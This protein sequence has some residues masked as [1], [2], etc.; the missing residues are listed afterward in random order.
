M[1]KADRH[2]QMFCTIFLLTISERD[3]QY[4]G[5]ELKDWMIAFNTLTNKRLKILSI[6]FQFQRPTHLKKGPK[7]Q[8]R[9]CLKCRTLSTVA[10]GTEKENSPLEQS[11]SERPPFCE[12]SSSQ[13]CLW[14]FKK[15]LWRH[16]GWG[17]TESMCTC[18]V[19]TSWGSYSCPM[20]H[21]YGTGK[22]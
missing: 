7:L 21:S 13:A 15:E 18:S 19:I 9:S 2:L 22:S 4:S 5:I 17:H 10:E 3:T 16:K 14:A 6:P 1:R 11:L 12:L 20:L 8:S